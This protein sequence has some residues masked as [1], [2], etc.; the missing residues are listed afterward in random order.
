[1]TVPLNKPLTNDP[2]WLAL[3]AAVAA[4]PTV[5]GKLQVVYDPQAGVP[6]NMRRVATQLILED[7]VAPDADGQD[8]AQVLMVALLGLRD[9]GIALLH[10]LD[11]DNLAGDTIQHQCSMP[12]GSDG[13][14]TLDDALARLA[15]V[16]P[17]AANM[18][19]NMAVGA[20]AAHDQA[21]SDALAAGF[22][23][24]FWYVV[25]VPFVVI[26]QAAAAAT[27]ALGASPFAWLIGGGVVLYIASRF[28][29][30]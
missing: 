8:A 22:A 16:D 18:I 26:G 25:K 9:K 11:L 21:Y 17:A 15:A 20:A 5:A 23:K 13:T 19:G 7:A 3:E 10:G 12:D 30:P 4:T 27:D 2:A 29:K 6:D 14:M 1:M 28:R 24:R